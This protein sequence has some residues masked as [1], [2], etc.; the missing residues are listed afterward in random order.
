MHPDLVEYKG[1]TKFHPLMVNWL[2]QFDDGSAIS[3]G[4][5]PE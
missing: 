1:M 5:Q 2:S 3:V 4:T